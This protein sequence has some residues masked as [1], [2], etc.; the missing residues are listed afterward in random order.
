[1]RKVQKIIDRLEEEKTGFRVK[2]IKCITDTERTIDDLK[3]NGLHKEVDKLIRLGANRNISTTYIAHDLNYDEIPY[4]DDMNNYIKALNK[5]CVYRSSQD[6]PRE[7]CE[8][9]VVPCEMSKEQR[10]TNT[11]YICDLIIKF[12]RR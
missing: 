11:K 6:K 7:G 12:E 2:E 9:R 3:N 4:S 8:K 10:M 5:K 1:M